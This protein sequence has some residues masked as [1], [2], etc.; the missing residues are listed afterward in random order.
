MSASDDAIP[1][2]NDASSA[3]PYRIHPS[4]LSRTAPGLLR[5]PVLYGPPYFRGL[6]QLDKFSSRPSLHPTFTAS[7]G[8][9]FVANFSA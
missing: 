7:R 3:C 2:L 6:Q 9:P 1:T 5:L 4:Q 8:P